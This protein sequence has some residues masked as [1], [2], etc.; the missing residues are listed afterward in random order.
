MA[1]DELCAE[2]FR[3]VLQGQAGLSEKKMMGGIC[4]LQNGN[5]I[6]GVDQTKEGVDRFMFRVGKDNDDEAQ[7]RPGANAMFQGGRR[8]TG[9]YFVGCEEC[10]EGLLKDWMAL[11]LSFVTPLPPKKPRKAKAK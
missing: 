11:A 6:G 7:G 3:N 9:F 10:D 8:M 2:R 4:F 1:F 5:M